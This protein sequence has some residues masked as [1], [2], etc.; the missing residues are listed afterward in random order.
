MVAPWGPTGDQSSPKSEF[1]HILGSFWE[2]SGSP[3]GI[4][5]VRDCEIGGI[6]STLWCPLSGL[7]KRSN[8]RA[9][10]GGG[11]MR[12][13]HAGAC[14][15]RVGPRRCGSV[16]GSILESFWEPSAPLCSLWVARVTKTG[17]QKRG[18]KNKK[19]WWNL[20]CRAGGR[21]GRGWGT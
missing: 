18:S 3:F 8:N 10:K 5:L 12:S 21:G 13:A 9:P 6:M 15:V 7:R 19:S 16:L 1:C 14:F 20:G 11:D 2:P 4:I 17:S